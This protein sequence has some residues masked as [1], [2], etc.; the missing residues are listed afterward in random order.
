MVPTT[1]YGLALVSINFQLYS[2]RFNASQGD[3][4][5]K[6]PGVGTS[7]IQEV[8]LGIVSIPKGKEDEVLKVTFEQFVLGYEQTK[9]MGTK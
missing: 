8:E 6:W 3:G 9:I 1:I 7:I 5:D 2:G 4:P